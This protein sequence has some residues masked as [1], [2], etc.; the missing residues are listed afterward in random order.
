MDVDASEDQEPL[1]FKHKVILNDISDIFELCKS[2][3]PTKYSSVLLF[4]TMRYFGVKW[5]DCNDFLTK[6]GELTSQ[7]AHKWASAFVT[8]DFDE[9]CN[10]N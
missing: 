7:T 1:N 5:K 9:F 6:I 10:D 2:K 4:M 3:C 8:G